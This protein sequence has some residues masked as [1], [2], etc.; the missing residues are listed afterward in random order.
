MFCPKCGKKQN[1]DQAKFCE[2]CGTKIPLSVRNSEIK[3]APKSPIIEL[4]IDPSVFKVYIKVFKGYLNDSDNYSVTLGASRT[5][6]YI[7]PVTSWEKSIRVAWG[8]L[9]ELK[10]KLQKKR[11]VANFGISD[12]AVPD[13][14]IVLTVKL[15]GDKFDAARLSNIFD[16]LPASAFSSMCPACFGSAIND[17]CENCGKSF[18]EEHRKLGLTEFVTGAIAMAS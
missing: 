18:S 12:S 14:V 17:V 1:E 3:L 2:D 8:D 16:R 4:D 5:E 13:S 10:N 6:M 11:F 15:T 7:Q 9:R